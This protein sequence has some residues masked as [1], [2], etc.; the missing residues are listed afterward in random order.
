MPLTTHPS[1]DCRTPLNAIIGMASLMQ[2][3]QLDSMQRESMSTIISSGELLLRVVNDVLDYSKLESGNV[4]VEIK[5]CRLQETLNA[6]V[7]SI[8]TSSRAQN[9]KI[10][11]VYAPTI[12][13]VI[14]TDSRR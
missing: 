14:S 6:V 7:R 11:T 12:G 2:Q 5:E 8:E 9:V 13:E 4:S 3:S 1:L 10:K